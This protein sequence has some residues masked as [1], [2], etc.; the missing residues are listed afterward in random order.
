MNRPVSSLVDNKKPI[1]AL[2]IGTSKVVAMLAYA[3]EQSFNISAI[4]QATCDGIKKGM[5][6][7]IQKTVQAIQKAVQELQSISQVKISNIDIGLSGHHVVGI[8]S[9]GAVAVKNQEVSGDDVNRAIESARAVKLA[10]DQ[11]LVHT[12]MQEFSVDNQEDIKD[13][14]GMTGVR[15]ELKVHLVATSITASQNVIKCARRCGLES[16]KL[17]VNPF[18]SS[19]AV[20]GKDEKELGVVLVDIGA[21]TTDIV[22][23]YKGNIRHIEVLPI[24]GDQITNDI[25]MALRIPIAEAEEIKIKYGVAR[26]RLVNPSEHIQVHDVG[27]T[28]KKISRQLLAAVIEPRLDELFRLILDVLKKSGYE[29]VIASGFVFTGGSVNINGFLD[30][31]NSVLRRNCRIGTPTYHGS[32]RDVVTDPKYASCIGILQNAYQEVEHNLNHK[33]G[34]KPVMQ[35]A[36]KAWNWLIGSF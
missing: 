24:A 5:V 9:H 36:K 12:F 3:D 35:A 11:Q 8:N 33:H 10:T 21:G 22:V 23:C 15:L 20:L 1:V 29:N 2:D 13:P 28:Y 17:V 30:L 26:Q 25:S 34:N 18:A 6:V 4:G 32:L 27:G 7:D 31:A 19:L 14:I 16:N